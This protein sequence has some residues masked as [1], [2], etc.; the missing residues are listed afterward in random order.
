MYI[1]CK[2]LD[3]DQICVHIL[4]ALKIVR[5]LFNNYT[6]LKVF[7]GLSA[8]VVHICKLVPCCGNMLPDPKLLG[9]DKLP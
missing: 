6:K 5:F 1:L 4:N 2:Y 9:G 8:A 3:F 7:L